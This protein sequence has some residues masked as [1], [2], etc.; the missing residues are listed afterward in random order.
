MRA[1]IESQLHPVASAAPAVRLADSP[2]IAGKGEENAR[3]VT[4]A[5]T[6]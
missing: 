3:S 4:R 1:E 2:L 5:S 6:D